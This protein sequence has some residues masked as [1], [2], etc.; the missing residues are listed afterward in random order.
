[1]VMVFFHQ[2]YAKHSFLVHNGFE[3]AVAAIVLAAKRESLP[4]YSIPSLWN[5][6]NCVNLACQF[7]KVEAINRDWKNILGDPDVDSLVSTCIQIC[8]LVA[9]CKV[10][11]T[12]TFKKIKA[13]LELLKSREDGAGRKSP[14]PSPPPPPASAKQPNAK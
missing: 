14:P 13:Q 12:D 3:V 9:D 10:S 2:F 6:T 1:M 7:S 5:A 8:E 11:D 4:K